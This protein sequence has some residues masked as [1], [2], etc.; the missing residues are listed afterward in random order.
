M[1]AVPSTVDHMA[2][3]MR[4]M[5]FGGQ[6]VTAEALALKGD[7]SKAEIERYG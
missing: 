5:A 2:S 4:E 1:Y 3:V 7:F 6:T